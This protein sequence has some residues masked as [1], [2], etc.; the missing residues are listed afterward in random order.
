MFFRMLSLRRGLSLKYADLW[1]DQYA[2]RF[3][4]LAVIG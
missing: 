3:S 2:F 4:H 1:D